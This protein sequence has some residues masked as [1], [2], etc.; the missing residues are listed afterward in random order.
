MKTNYK[1][2]YASGGIIFHIAVFFFIYYMNDFWNGYFYK[3]GINDFCIQL[4]SYQLIAY[5]LFCILAISIET[6][7]LIKKQ[8]QFY[9]IYLLILIVQC[10]MLIIYLWGVF[11]K[12]GKIDHSLG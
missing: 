1:Y 8:E 6:I 4:S 11:D 5:T 9:T 12:F 2:I 7:I 10:L 3:I